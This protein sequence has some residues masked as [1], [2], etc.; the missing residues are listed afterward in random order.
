MTKLTVL[1]V[2]L[3]SLP[4]LVGGCAKT[5]A[6]TR[7]ETIAPGTEDSSPPVM[8]EDNTRTENPPATA[9]AGD[10]N[11]KKVPETG[12]LWEIPKDENLPGKFYSDLAD[13]FMR[14]A[15]FD[16]AQALFEEALDRETNDEYKSLYFSKLAEIA[17]RLHKNEEAASDYEKAVELTQNADNKKKYYRDLARIYA[18]IGQP[19]KAVGAYQFLYDQEEDKSK[20]ATLK[21]QLY[22]AYQSAGKIE[23]LISKYEKELQQNPESIPALEELVMIY[24]QITKE[25]AKAV[26]CLEKLASIVKPPDNR[27]YLNQLASKYAQLNLFD[28]QAGILLQIAEQ[29]PES[30]RLGYVIRVAQIYG[31]AGNADKAKEYAE[32]ALQMKPDDVSTLLQVAY[33]YV[34]LKQNEKATELFDKAIELSKTDMQKQSTFYQYAMACMT[35]KDYDKADELFTKA[36]DSTADPLMKLQ[37]IS[38]VSGEFLNLKLQDRADKWAAKMIE[39]GPDNPH[40][41]VSLASYYY[42]NKKPEKAREVIKNAIDKMST[43]EN[44]VQLL[45]P[46]VQ[47]LMRTK[48]YDE[49]RE[50]LGKIKSLTK[51]EMIL[52]WVARSEKEID[53]AEKETPPEE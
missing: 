37:L 17:T 27:T 46:Y 45:V 16:S 25:P 49:A 10:E 44:K 42:R 32:K 4:L 28:K 51:E 35:M 22:Q 30:Q 50:A 7:T 38:T 47:D 8:Q 5:Q 23:D 20:Q 14:Y 26:P 1:M 40:N 24:S 3:C 12:D 9:V 34:P 48:D 2:V 18:I 53:K 39:I 36:M 33:A 15:K 13:V 11:T 31:Q 41:Y 43:P 6:V 52:D 19:D 29:V 21:R